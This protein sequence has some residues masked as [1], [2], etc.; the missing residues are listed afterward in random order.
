[1]SKDFDWFNVFYRLLKNRKSARKSRRRRKEELHYLRD[2]IDLLR[3]ENAK[4]KAMLKEQ[5][6]GI[7]NE[8]V[9]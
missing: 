6:K 3:E 5:N 4:L 7:S 9:K 1:M 2:E 8:E